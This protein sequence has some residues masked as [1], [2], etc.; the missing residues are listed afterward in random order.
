MQQRFK[1]LLENY[2]QIERMRP[3]HLKTAAAAFLKRVAQLIED[4]SSEEPD[5][6]ERRKAF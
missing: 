6:S 4:T 5:G 2:G 1:E 3:V